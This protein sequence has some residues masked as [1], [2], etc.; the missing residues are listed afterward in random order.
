MKS[1]EI[2]TLFNALK[3]TVKFSG[4]FK[5]THLKLRFTRMTH[6]RLGEKEETKF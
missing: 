1:C 6:L 2:Y 3:I 5:D 4:E